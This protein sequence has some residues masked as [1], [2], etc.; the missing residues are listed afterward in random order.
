MALWI[1]K[2][3]VLHSWGIIYLERHRLTLWCLLQINW[4]EF[5]WDKTPEPDATSIFFMLFQESEV[6]N[7]IS[8]ASANYSPCGVTPHQFLLGSCQMD[9]KMQNVRICPSLSKL[10][11]IKVTGKLQIC[12]FFDTWLERKQAMCFSFFQHTGLSV[13]GTEGSKRV[14]VL[15]WSGIRHLNG[16]WYTSGTVNK[17]PMNN[18]G[19]FW[20]GYIIARIYVWSYEHSWFL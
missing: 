7:L 4:D 5:F 3:W 18:S 9:L 10:C 1:W 2:F 19:A 6:V 16:R 15:D 20:P 11:V 17:P 12:N 13:L 8:L 14:E